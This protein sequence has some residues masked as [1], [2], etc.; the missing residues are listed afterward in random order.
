MKRF[1]P[2]DAI[3]NEKVLAQIEDGFEASL[4]RLIQ[5]LSIPSISTDPAFKEEIADAAAWLV[6]ELT[7]LDF[8]VEAMPTA[9]H[10]CVVARPRE[11]VVA[12]AEDRPTV[13]FYGHYDVQPPDPLD[14]WTTGPFEPRIR[15]GAVVARGASDDKGQVLCFIEA[16]RA[17]K[18]AT[19]RLPLNVI[20]VIEGEEECGS[21][22][23]PAFL[24]EHRSMLAADVVLVSDTCMWDAQ[25]LAITCGLRGLVYFDIQLRGPNRDLHSGTF[26]GTVPNPAVILTQVLAS[27]WDE[28]HRIT[29]PG[30]YDDVAA[31][32]DAE[33]AQW[34][35]LGFDEQAYL[36]AVGLKQGFGEAGFDLLERRWARPSLEINGLY[37]GYMGEGAK[38]VIPAMAGAKLSFRIPPNMNPQKVVEQ[39]ESWLLSREVHG[40][41]WTIK[42]HG[43][44]APVSLPEDS[45]WLP[46]IERA[47]HLTSGRPPVRVREGATIPILADFKEI[48][49]LD[50]ILVGLGRDDDRIHAPDEKFE[51]SNYRLGIRTHAAVLA[52]LA[53]TGR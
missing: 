14:L 26:G 20:L 42:R 51:L 50:S 31:V 28:Q 5:W 18:L 49:G 32:S 35:T 52:E 46:A 7:E 9:G 11:G 29:I 21:V 1:L 6:H 2:M 15:N 23:L 47:C 8:E 27:L 53:A 39:F 4:Q 44:A 33:R 16:L 45:P 40:L 19:G 34:K 3:M 43:A 36:G 22:N 13:L 10:P 48:L 38:T 30:L 17:W 12:H 41:T 24:K 37:G 25:T